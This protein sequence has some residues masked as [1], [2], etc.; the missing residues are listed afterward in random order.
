MQ[1]LNQNLLKEI[2]NDDKIKLEKILEVYKNQ[3]GNIISL[4]Q[5][6]QEQ[7]G[8]L[9]ENILNYLSEELKI[10]ISEI[11]G[12]ATF[13]SQFTFTEKGKYIIICCDGTACHVKGA[14]LLLEFLE[15]QLNIKSGQ[16][17]KD[18]L[19]SLEVV[20]CLG[21]C[22][23]SPVCIINN[24]IYGNLNIRKLKKILKKL[25]KEEKISLSPK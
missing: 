15:N 5:H 7:Y 3:K 4:L 17:S 10:S 18:K 19:F 13:Y 24:K 22:A 23:I 21:C 14:P 11:Y 9:P 16:T 6:V 1:K 25:E 2:T 12:I 8:Y 20:R